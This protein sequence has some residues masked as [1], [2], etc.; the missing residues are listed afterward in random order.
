MGSPNVHISHCPVV[1]QGLPE[2]TAFPFEFSN[3]LG[4]D[5]FRT[6]I[7]IATIAHWCDVQGMKVH[8]A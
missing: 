1:L 3:Q 6:N 8:S 2:V 5:F 7:H 4:R